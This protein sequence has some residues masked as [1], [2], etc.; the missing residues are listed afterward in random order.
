LLDT[1]PEQGLAG[2]TEGKAMRRKNSLLPPGLVLDSTK[3]KDKSQLTALIYTTMLD[4][5]QP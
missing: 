2:L 4:D 5:L 1:T 3:L